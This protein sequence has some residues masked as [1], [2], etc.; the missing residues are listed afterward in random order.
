MMA[1]KPKTA[2]TDMVVLAGAD[3]VVAITV[4]LGAATSPTTG[5]STPEAARTELRD[6]MA[7][8]VVF[9]LAAVMYIADVVA[10][11]ALAAEATDVKVALIPTRRAAAQLD[12]MEH[13][14]KNTKQQYWIS[15]M[16]WAKATAWLIM[17]SRTPVGFTVIEGKV[18]TCV[19]VAEP[20]SGVVGAVVGVGSG[21]GCGL[22]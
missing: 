2:T 15:P 16:P 7:F 22:G 12:L 19:M 9:R 5:I 1:A 21:V 6:L 13:P 14:V 4:A 18:Q 8:M 11:V 17:L 3:A 20:A 10:A